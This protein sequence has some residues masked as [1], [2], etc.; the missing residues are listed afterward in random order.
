MFEDLTI[1]HNN[2]SLYRFL[3]SR[4]GNGLL[5]GQ[6]LIFNN[7]IDT[8]GVDGDGNGEVEFEMEVMKKLIV[9]SPSI[10]W[11]NISSWI[12]IIPLL[13]RSLT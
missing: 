12:D 2:V 3:L 1:S 6:V 9:L 8:R 7:N 13:N 11:Y 10:H 4:L 5:T